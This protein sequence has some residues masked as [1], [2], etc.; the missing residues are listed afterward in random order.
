MPR[1]IVISALVIALSLS[2]VLSLTPVR[3]QVIVSDDFNSLSSQYVITN[4]SGVSVSNGM[5]HLTQNNGGFSQVAI[6][7]SLAPS[8]TV[9]IAVLAHS[10][11]RFQVA[12]SPA[13]GLGTYL[14]WNNNAV[15]SELDAGTAT[16]G[17][18]AWEAASNWNDTYLCE[19]LPSTDA[20]YYN[21]ETWYRLQITANNN[22]VTWNLLDSSGFTL[23]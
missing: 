23:Q 9:T 11:D 5:L 14:G 13:I 12:L 17:N 7:I 4:P 22:F 6:P 20:H 1:I 10:F 2:M 16:C 19:N 21:I 15:G 3:G 18:F 8:M